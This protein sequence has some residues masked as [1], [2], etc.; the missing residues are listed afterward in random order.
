MRYI[1]SLG[2]S[3]I[4]PGKIDIK[5]LKDFKKLIL[6]FAGKDNKFI[7]ITGGGSLARDY[8]KAARQIG[9]PSDEDL[10]W[11]GIAAT[12]IN[13]ELLKAVFG[14]K[15][16]VF[17]G[18]KP[19]RSTDYQSVKIAQKHGIK[20]VLNLSNIDYVYSADPKKNKRAKK[21]ESMTWPAFLKRF[22]VKWTPGANLPFDPVAAQFARKHRIK[23]V[24]I[25]GRNIKNL[26]NFLFG[27][28][29]KGTV[30]K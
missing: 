29:F 16:K 14:K 27:K 18:W 26:K 10:D 28:P 20:T 1:V 30:I 8:Q 11:I 3:L 4:N 9:R 19:G 2:G 5:F 7:F 12:K 13:A 22:G 23:V 25:N 15:A 24:V 17:G 6:E 21:F